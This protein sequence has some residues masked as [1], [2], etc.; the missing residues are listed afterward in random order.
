M[1][2]HAIYGTTYKDLEKENKQLKEKINKIKEL[3]KNYEELEKILGAGKPRFR[4]YKLQEILGGE[5]NG[6]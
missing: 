5:Q 1:K 2:L 3:V 6:L 4:L